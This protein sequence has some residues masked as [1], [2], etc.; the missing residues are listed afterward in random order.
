MADPNVNNDD[1]AMMKIIASDNQC[2][3]FEDD[4]N[5]QDVNDE[6]Q[7]IADYEDIVHDNPLYEQENTV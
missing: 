7:Y 4:E 2:A 6:S 3:G 5:N 1:D